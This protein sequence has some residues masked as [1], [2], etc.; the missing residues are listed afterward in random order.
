MTGFIDTNDM[1][2][3][4]IRYA[5]Y[6]VLFRY[7]LGYPFRSV[8]WAAAG[9]AGL[10]LLAGLNPWMWSWPLLQITGSYYIHVGSYIPF[11]FLIIFLIVCNERL[12]ISISVF[13]VSLCQ[14]FLDFFFIVSDRILFILGQK[15]TIVAA[16]MTGGLI[17]VFAIIIRGRKVKLNEWLDMVPGWVYLLSAVGLMFTKNYYYT[18][19]NIGSLKEQTDLFNMVNHSAT[20]I[21]LILTL[22]GILII[23]GQ[24]K[25][26]KERDKVNTLL[27]KGQT[28][29]WK[30]QNERQKELRAFRHDFAAHALALQ[31]LSKQKQYDKLDAYIGKLTAVQKSVFYISTNHIIGDAILNEYQ[32]RGKEDSVEIQVVGMFPD[33]ME[34][35]EM[36]LCTILS[37]LMSN[38]YEATL[39]VDTEGERVIKVKIGAYEDRIFVTVDNPLVG[40]LQIEDGQLL[41]SKED[42][43]G[44]GYGI[45]NVKKALERYGGT[46]SW[47]LN[48]E[49]EGY[50]HFVTKAIF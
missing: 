50:R 17:L 15:Q 4:L 7:V 35:E 36:D 5:G 47:E 9:I 23:Y 21:L 6:V 2:A 29:Q 26:L 46:I 49:T 12:R 3:A 30:L 39:K 10:I 14:V 11:V 28:N 48:D 45:Q 19:G 18:I 16:I 24:R 38:A 37:N 33:E 42:K 43:E 22:M 44:H 13:F 8:R 1:L 34:M 20:T 25:R 31:S 41:T 32:R 40:D 27:I